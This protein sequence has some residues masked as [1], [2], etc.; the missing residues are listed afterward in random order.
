MIINRSLDSSTKHRTRVGQLGLSGQRAA[1]AACRRLV[2]KSAAFIKKASQ[3]NF[4][5]R[6]KGRIDLVTEIDLAAEDLVVRGLRK[7][8]PEAEILAE[9]KGLVQS[10]GQ[11]GRFILD[12][13]DGTTNMTHG[14][15]LFAVSLAFEDKQGLAFG[16]VRN[17]ISGEEFYA[18][19]GQGA[20]LGS[21]KLKVSKEKYLSNALLATGFSYSKA[22][23]RAATK[24]FKDFLLSAQGVR[25]LGSAALDLCY[26][27]AGRFDGFWELGLKPWD[28][29]AGHLI[30]EEAGGKVTDYSNKPLGN[31]YKKLLATN[32]KIHRAMLN[33]LKS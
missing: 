25:R 12:P 6:H 27:A 11:G 32:R 23:M 19:R 21:Q 4:K 16:I 24:H 28:A 26:V 8:F 2:K 10:Q 5:V 17:P 29:A 1:L 3:G 30:I 13:V 7:N 31:N 14:L 22:E 15:P 33:I 20:W 18:L 9:E